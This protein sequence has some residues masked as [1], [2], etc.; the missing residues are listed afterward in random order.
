MESLVELLEKYLSKDRISQLSE[1]DRHCLSQQAMLCEQ[2]KQAVNGEVCPDCGS[3]I[4]VLD[5]Q[6][7]VKFSVPFGSFERIVVVN[8]FPEG[9]DFSKAQVH[10]LNCAKKFSGDY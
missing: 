5:A 3:S 9:K 2:V 4:F 1:W 10:C 7:L 6:V 8:G